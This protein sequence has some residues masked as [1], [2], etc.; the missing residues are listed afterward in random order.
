LYYISVG[1][2]SAEPEKTVTRAEWQQ[3]DNRAVWNGRS[4]P[5]LNADR[6]D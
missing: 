3:V 5:L 4:L 1:R 6:A 2:P